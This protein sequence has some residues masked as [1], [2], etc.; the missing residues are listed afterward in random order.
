MSATDEMN[1]IR[2]MRGNAHM[3]RRD[4]GDA[5]G[6]TE[7]TIRRYEKGEISVSLPMLT[8]IATALHCDPADLV[9]SGLADAASDAEPA[10]SP[11]G[12]PR[13][14]DLLGKKGLRLY[15]VLTEVLADAGIRRGE[16]IV[17]D[18][19][20]AAIAARRAGDVLIV[21]T[22]TPNLLLLRQYLPPRLLVTNRFGADNSTLKLDDKTIP[23]AVLGVVVRAD[24]D[25]RGGV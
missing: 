18:E 2:E 11:A 25:D 15:R 13:L 23:L 9:A 14:A 20:E 1:R 10:D 16:Q 21:K 5:V 24:D 22:E 8:K 6:V 7:H 17:V 12:L 19:T 3:S 4:L